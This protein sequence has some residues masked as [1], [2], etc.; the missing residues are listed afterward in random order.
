MLLSF[1]VGLFSKFPFSQMFGPVKKNLIFVS[2]IEFVLIAD[3]Y[4][5]VGQGIKRVYRFSE[6]G[7]YESRSRKE[8][9]KLE[10]REF[11]P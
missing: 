3:V 10:S 11:E 4:I 6:K 7:N 1:R 9:S 2:R 8:H 5:E